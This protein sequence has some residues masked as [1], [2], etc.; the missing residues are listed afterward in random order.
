[1]YRNLLTVD[2]LERIDIIRLA[3]ENR[4]ELAA[5]EGFIHGPIAVPQ[6]ILEQLNTHSV[7]AFRLLAFFKQIP[8][9]NQVKIDDKMIL[10]KYNLMH[11]IV[12]NNAAS[13]QSVPNK[14]PQIDGDVP[15]NI[16]LLERVHGQSILPDLQR[17]FR[18]IVEIARADMKIF[19]MVFIVFILLKGLSAGEGVPEPILEDGISVYRAQ[20]IFTELLW[21]YLETNHGSHAATRIMST[22][23]TKF[24][25]WQV[26]YL[27]MRSNVN[28]LVSV[29]DENRLLPLMKSIF[30]I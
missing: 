26:Y 22:I 4:I 6:N 12:L 24:M 27:K 5:Q 11:V 18:P 8:E 17:I 16:H 21:K 25:S 10:I 15:W 20:N 28:Q 2:D 19:P 30:H 3:F 9:F 14:L 13:F 7:A 1:M 23:V 29:T